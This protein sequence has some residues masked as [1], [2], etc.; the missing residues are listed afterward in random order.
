MYVLLLK[1]TTG[2]G[3]G[4][5]G[6][7]SGTI[8][9]TAADDWVNTN[10]NDIEEVVSPDFIG[11]EEDEQEEADHNDCEALEDLMPKT[12]TCTGFMTFA[13]LGPIVSDCMVN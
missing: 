9:T 2:G 4:S 6:T 7:K 12:W 8:E 1:T 5:G 11:N 13:L 3:R 10:K